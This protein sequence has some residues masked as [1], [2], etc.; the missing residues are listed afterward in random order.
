MFSFADVQDCIDYGRLLDFTRLAEGLELFD[1]DQVPKRFLHISVECW[2]EV[3][4][5]S[6]DLHSGAI[7]ELLNFLL[8]ETMSWGDMRDGNHLKPLN[9]QTR[10]VEFKNRTSPQ[11]RLYGGFV[12]IDHFIVMHACFRNDQP[13]L[14]VFLGERWITL[15]GQNLERLPIEDPSSV[16]T[17]YM[18]VR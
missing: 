1:R 2:D 9:P 14:D 15:W 12:D 5:W 3:E 8:G 4:A 6:E 7:A 11:T 17:N 13:D 16:L 18:T 10:W